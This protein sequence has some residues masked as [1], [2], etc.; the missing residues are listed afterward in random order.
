MVDR[1]SAPSPWRPRRIWL[2]AFSAFFLLNAGWALALPPNGT[3]DEKQHIVRAYAVADGQFLPTGQRREESFLGSDAFLV[4]A[5]LLP[6]NP[7]CLWYPKPTAAW[8]QQPI[9]DPTP[10]LQTS[11]AARYSPAYYLPVGLPMLISPNY[12]GV[13]AGRLVSALLA[14]LVLS[15]AV[16]AA[17]RLR[18]RLVVSAV[19]LVCTP[20]VANL[21]GAINPNGLEIDAA[22]LLF[23]ALLALLRADDL[24]ERGVRRLTWLAGLAIGLLFVLRLLGPV[25]VTVDVA[26]CLVL[27]RPGRVRALLRRSHARWIFGALASAGFAYFVAWSILS[28]DANYGGTTD[29]QR[30]LSALRIA[31]QIAA[32]RI[33]FYL[34]QSVGQ[35]GYGET[36]VSPFVIIIWYGLL[37]ALALPAFVRGSRRTRL[38]LAGLAGAWLVILVGLDAYFVRTLGWI[39]H[40]RY[41]LPIAVGIV[42]GAACLRTD[43]PRWDL[44]LVAATVPLHV[45]TLGSVLTR[46]RLGTDARFDPFRGGWSPLLGPAVPL[47]V[48]AAGALML[49]WLV[50]VA[51]PVAQRDLGH[52][53]LPQR[54]PDVAK[55]H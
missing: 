46:Y 31:E 8:C 6:D 7:H 3:Y 25:L 50:A 2:L 48:G 17:M 51:R 12:A 47:L 41:G 42:I 27:A 28:R 9:R 16:G 55:I 32:H 18:S 49:T 5:S 44:A 54:V 38:A 23:A 34:Q 22:V 33:P 14:A 30:G 20:M 26:A 45:Y 13:V 37:A 29:R 15:G 1:A 19:V 36:H 21:N 35:F 52:F 4:P 39:S 10:I 11:G 40:G 24:D 43:V 53:L